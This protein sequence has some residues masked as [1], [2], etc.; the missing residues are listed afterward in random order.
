MTNVRF[1]TWNLNNVN[2]LKS[3]T[4]FH[5]T[6]FPNTQASKEWIEWYSRHGMMF[7][8]IPTRAYV[9]IR[10]SDDQ[11]VGTWCVEPKTFSTPTK[12]VLVG[13]C[14]SV[15]IHPDMRR[16]NLFVKLSTH[17]IQTEKNLGQFK[18][19]LGFPWVGRPVIAAHVKSGWRTLLTIPV[20]GAIPYNEHISMQ[21]SRCITSNPTKL[22]TYVSSFIETDE[23]IHRRWL[24]HP[25]NTYIVLTSK[26]ARIVLKHYN[27]MMHVLSIAG[28]EDNVTT[29]LRSARTLAFRHNCTEL[30]VWCAAGEF[31][32][33]SLQK[34]G[35][36]HGLSK[37][38][39]TL[40]MC[41]DLT[42]ETLDDSIKIC[43]LHQGIEEIY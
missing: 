42:N 30:N 35:F 25:D 34:T 19:I 33:N 14:F 29:L 11:L 4:K 13:R 26:N 15:G 9:A 16:Q 40:M 12:D 27:T 2:D 43:A 36:A 32:R 5:N 22:P 7:H 38:P 3:F 41:V 8:D 31:Y 10:E 39:D 6:I 37:T 17:A 20:L 21:S 28:D 18:H 24:Q 1:E 23:Y